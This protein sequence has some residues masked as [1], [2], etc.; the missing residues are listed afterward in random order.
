MFFLYILQHPL[1]RI[2]CRW[3]E[4]YCHGTK[5]LRKKN[6]KDVRVKKTVQELKTDL[7]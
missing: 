2:T 6:R 5:V 1:I 4:F 3:I 7:L